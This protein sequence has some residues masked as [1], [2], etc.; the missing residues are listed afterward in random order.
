M[1][2]TASIMLP[3]GTQAPD[4]TLQDTISSHTISLPKKNHYKATVIIFICNHCP[5]VKH[6]SQEL[7]RVANDYN[8]HNVAF[9][10]INSND[11]S[12]YPDDAPE[13][14]K[15]IGETQNYPFPYLFDETQ[16][17]ARA[18]QAACTPD[19]FVFNADLCLS[20]RGQFDDSRP[21]N[22]IPQDGLSLRTALDCIINNMPIPE[23]QKPSIGCNIKWK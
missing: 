3:L 2:K 17:V 9:I 19:F 18:Y 4:F 11:T 1:V 7:I 13:Q 15:A 20:Y 12:A 16:E 6:I 22:N 10:A 21:G 14:M 8:P 5:F 23:P